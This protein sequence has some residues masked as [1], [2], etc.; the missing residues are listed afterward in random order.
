MTKSQQVERLLRRGY[1]RR[2]VREAVECSPSLVAAVAR[3]IRDGSP[4]ARRGG[5]GGRYGPQIYSVMCDSP[6]LSRR[7]VARLVGCSVARVGQVANFVTALVERNHR[8]GAGCVLTNAEY[9]I[10]MRNGWGPCS[11]T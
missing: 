3:T 9:A 8:N 1:S 11:T 2:H 4:P 7:D 10:A 5:L 6:E